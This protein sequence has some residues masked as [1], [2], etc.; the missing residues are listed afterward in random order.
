MRMHPSLTNSPPLL[1][2][3]AV[4]SGML[5]APV[6]SARTGERQLLR[7]H[8]PAA[9]AALK[10]QPIER[11]PAT[12]RLNLAIGLPWR[13]QEDLAALLRQIYDPASDNFHHY[14][15][16][17]EFTERF[18][19]SEKDY[20]ALIAFAKAH[21]LKVAAT[22]PNRMVLDV[23]ASVAEIEAAF[24]VT[25]QSYQHPADDRR[26]YAPD[27][28]PSLDLTVPILHI[29]GL[30][31]YTL[32]RPFFRATPLEQGPVSHSPASARKSDFSN[33]TAIIRTTSPLMR[34]WL[35]CRVSR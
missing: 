11:L 7:D 35:D 19:P 6:A 10:L 4:T 33:W 34:A 8:V 13:N 27:K 26:F 30:D 25:L 15:S 5:L 14:L 12:N 1:V 9:V 31:N 21:G 22:Y 20:Q 2:I 18:G 28:E 3:A 24:H 17:K 29:S 32:P 16:S 23:T